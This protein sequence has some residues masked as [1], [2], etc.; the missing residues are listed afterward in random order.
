MRPSS[1]STIATNN[2]SYEL[3]GLLLSIGVHHPKSKVYIMCDQITKNEILDITPKPNIQIFWVVELDKYS[4][5]NRKEMEAQGIFTEFL[6]NKAKI[7]RYALEKENDTLFLDNDIILVNPIQ[8]IKR[9][10][11]LGVSRQYLV[12]ESL[13]ETGYFNAGML[14][15]SSKRVCDDWIKYTETSRYFEQAAIENLV[16]KY[17]H[18]EFGEEYN[19]QAWRQLFNPE[20]TSFELFFSSQSNDNVYY[21]KKPLRCIHTHFRDKRFINFN[22][23]VLQH[24]S[25]A[26]KYKEMMIIYRVMRGAWVLKVPSN[27]HQNSFRELAIML[28]EKNK[29]V[30][31][32]RTEELHCWLEPNILLYD[33]PS[34][35]W[36]DKEVYN[37]SLF[38]LGNGSVEKEGQ[39]VIDKTDVPV[40]PWIFWP[41]CPRVMEYYIENNRYPHFFER[42]VG[43]I[44]IG[45]IENSVQENYRKPL[46]EDWKRSVDVFECYMGKEHKYSALQYIEKLQMSKYGLCLRGYGSKCHREI[47]LMA[48]GTVPIVT[49]DVNTDS[50][51]EPLIEGEHYFNIQTPAELRA[52]VEL[53]PESIWRKM[54]NACIN[55]YQRNVHSDNAWK[56]MMHNILHF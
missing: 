15:T 20:K 16:T 13:E 38:L 18:F 44:F 41:R 50:Y 35:E 42:T 52:I 30:V 11:K 45:N 22:N 34:L 21:K 6:L 27:Q 24:L 7:M 53:T 48:L 25:K 28:A 4:H 5:I 23:L 3:V 51:L 56:S 54:S 39:Q 36:C 31:I 19:V 8:D 43:S 17:S 1:F 10:T 32:K 2:T 55:W 49:E 37:A 33:R 40:L 9:N 26:K 14:W 29:D 47:E 46:I 12:R